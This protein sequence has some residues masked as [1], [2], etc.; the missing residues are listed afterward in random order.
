MRNRLLKSAARGVLVGYGPEI[1]GTL[2]YFLHDQDED[3]WV[4]RHIPSTLAQIP[5]TA[6]RGPARRRAR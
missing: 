3:I 1:L 5:D 2:E 4:R 6:I